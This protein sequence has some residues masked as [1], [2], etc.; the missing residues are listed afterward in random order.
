M[1]ETTRLSFSID[2]SLLQKLEDLL[3]KGQYENRS[4]FIRDLVRGRLV[5]EEW[6]KDSPA[7]GTITLLYDHHIHNLSEKLNQLQHRHHD[8]IMAST[9]VHVDAH[10]CAE[11]I[12]VRAK[13]SVIREIADLLRQQK[14]VLHAGL[15]LSS[16][17]K[18]LK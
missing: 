2:K 7:L 3:E 17:G 4:E 9:H 8:A 1:A 10:I 6:E 14:G 16:L 12:M 13:S 15:S 5:E 11:M 18:D